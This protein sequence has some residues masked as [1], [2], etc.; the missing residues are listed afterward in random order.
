[1]TQEIAKGLASLA[2]WRLTAEERGLPL[3]EQKEAL[4]DRQPQVVYNMARDSMPVFDRDV[5]V[6][7]AEVVCTDDEEGLANA[8]FCKGCGGDAS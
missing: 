5:V 7:S 3:K 1:M 8:F 6:I 2:R 4:R